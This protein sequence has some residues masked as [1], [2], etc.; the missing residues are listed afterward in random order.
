M[1]RVRFR[2][3][4]PLPSYLLALGVGDFDVVALPA[5][6]YLP[7]WKHGCTEE[8]A[9]ALPG[10][11]ALALARNP[12]IGLNLRKAQETARLCAAVQ[13]PRPPASTRS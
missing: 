6:Q 4:R 8:A 12:G 10:E 9:D 1:K 2:T 5:P 3:T 11:L 7:L 13:A